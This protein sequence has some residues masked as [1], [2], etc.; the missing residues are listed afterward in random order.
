MLP[1]QT[2]DDLN[3]GEVAVEKKPLPP[4]AEQVTITERFDI[5]KCSSVQELI[6]SLERYIENHR[7]YASIPADKI[8]ILRSCMLSYQGFGP[9]R[10]NFED[11]DMVLPTLLELYKLV[12]AGD[13]DTQEGDLSQPDLLQCRE[14]KD[15]IKLLYPLVTEH[16]QFAQVDAGGR[17]GA[18]SF[19][20]DYL[21]SHGRPG[22]V[23][24][25]FMLDDLLNKNAQL[26][27]LAVSAVVSQSTPEVIAATTPSFD[28]S[29]YPDGHSFVNGLYAYLQRHPQFTTIPEH[30]KIELASFITSFRGLMERAGMGDSFRPME[31][32]LNMYQQIQQGASPVREGFFDIGKCKNP[33]ALVHAL[34]QHVQNHQNLNTLNNDYREMLEGFYD[35]YKR[36]NGAAV[37]SMVEF[38]VSTNYTLE[39][40]STTK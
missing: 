24:P 23:G 3:L 26:H 25:G 33:D 20:R 34:Y 8:A 2:A 6:A 14:A 10:N 35:D 18:E 36:R 17:D 19:Y 12:C 38:L 32:M 39:H 40:T 29:Q 7:L 15:L 28:I 21:D 22:S 16:P 31:M 30:E 4:A 1:E 9:S 37:E 5:S 13:E 11:V 27:V